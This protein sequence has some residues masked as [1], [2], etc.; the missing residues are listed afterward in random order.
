MHSH[1]LRLAVCAAALL[2]SGC[3]SMAPALDKPAVA[4]PAAYAHGT[5]SGAQG[6]TAAATLAWRDY[7]TDPVLAQL[8]AQ[9][10]ANNPDM[11]TAVLR[12]REAQAAYG[13]QRADRLPTIGVGLDATRARTPADLSLSGRAA[14]ASQYQAGLGLSSWEIDLWGRIASLNEAALQSFLATDAARRAVSVSLVA[15]V[16]DAYLGLR[17][18][19]ERL[20]LAQASETSQRESLRIFTRRLEVGSASRL[21]LTQVQTLLT[22]AESL[23]VQVQQERDA[24][25]LALSILVGDLS[26]AAIPMDDATAVDAD[27]LAPVSPGLPSDLLYSRPDVVAAEHQLR[28][29]NANIGAARAAFFPSIS[30]TG[31]IGSGSSELS[32]LFD[33]GTRVWSFLPKI[34]LPIFQGG[35]LRANLAI[36]N[37]DRDIALAQYEKSIQVG[38]RETADA[39]AL[40]VSLDE[41]V[42]AQQRLVDAA[43]QANRLSQARYDAGLD[44][45]VTLLDAR[46]TAY[47]AQQTQLQAQLAQQAN[48]ITL[49][50]VL[51]GGWH[52]RS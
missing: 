41:Q 40:N 36:A 24:Q 28:G 20:R 42:S 10:L 30:L 12:V 5:P 19:Q 2:M 1:S 15:E 29:A 16:A 32:N 13:V 31:S 43:E 4:M 47:N 3:A 34:T 50:K 8:I 22:Q 26:D 35:K 27:I 37:A 46:R 44:S 39:L 17:E 23:V 18:L 52:E 49:Y 14:T 25:R 45:F 6:S 38:F 48:R 33:S 11:R 21:E 7:F 51:G 9:A